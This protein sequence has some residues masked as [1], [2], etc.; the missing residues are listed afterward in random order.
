MHTHTHTYTHNIILNTTHVPH[1]RTSHIHIDAS[2]T[3]TTHMQS[4]CTHLVRTHTHTHMKPMYITANSVH[5]STQTGLAPIRT[6]T[7]PYIR[8]IIDI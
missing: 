3:N 8:M 2:H 7:L 5:S 4:P 1:T 6:E